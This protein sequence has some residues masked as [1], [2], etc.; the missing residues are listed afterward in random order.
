MTHDL[1]A[2]FIFADPDRA[3]LGFG[4]VTEA[5]DQRHQPFRIGVTAAAD[6]ETEPRTIAGGL[7]KAALGAVR[8]DARGALAFA[9]THRHG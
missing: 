6:I 2:G 4:D 9:V 5:T 1:E 8:A 7:D 3:D